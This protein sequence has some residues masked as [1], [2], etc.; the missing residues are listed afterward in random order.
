[1]TNE[2]L[3][4]CAYEAFDIV[5][6]Q[7]ASFMGAP[8]AEER[9]IICAMLAKVLHESVSSSDTATLPADQLRETVVRAGQTFLRVL[10][11]K[12]FNEGRATP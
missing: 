11:E 1:M 12:M 4:S 7:T 2:E 6:V 3:L 5:A 10:V 9:E 8:T